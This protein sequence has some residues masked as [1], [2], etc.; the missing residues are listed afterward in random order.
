MSVR[1]HLDLARSVLAD[2][3]NSHNRL[4][5]D[6]EPV[7]A[8]DS[9]EELELDV[10]DG[11]DGQLAAARDSAALRELDFDSNHPL[12]GP[13][14]LRGAQPGDVAVIEPLAIEPRGPGTTA[15]IPSFGLL[16]ERFAQ[17][18]LVRWEIA[19]GIARSPALPGIA[20]RGRP[21]LGCIAVAPSPELL[22]A[23]R[24][25]EDAVA[26]RGGFALAPQRA[27]AV[28]AVEP[29]AS[30]GL[31]TIPPRENGGNLD[32][33]QAGVGSRVLLTVGV[34]DALISIGDAHFAQGEGECAG[35]AIE[36][37]ARVRVRI[38]L[39]RARD[40]A[41]ALRFPAIEHVEPPSPAARRWF[42]TTGIPIDDAGAN[43]DLDLTLAARQALAEMIGWLASERGLRAE[44]AYALASVAADLRIAQAVN[45][46]NGL[47]VCR[48]P[49]DVF[50]DDAPPAC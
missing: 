38:S 33:P 8:V 42:V 44:Q 19:D 27:G 41:R 20:V 4:W 17:P 28:P 22:A 2:P 1:L 21:F 48:L 24:E 50:E 14:A 5:P 32:V 13:I 39:R 47:V 6:L 15:V 45:R 7:L 9:G 11:M 10:R 16:G 37:A 34:P 40:G 30:G 29:Y 18:F 35:T 49:L 43:A 46:P 23:A 36:I 31:R 3:V 25:R 26:R 12:T